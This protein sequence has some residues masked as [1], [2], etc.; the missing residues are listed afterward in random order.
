MKS[1][2]VWAFVAFF[3]GVSATFFLFTLFL[4]NGECTCVGK[5]E[6]T[7]ADLIGIQHLILIFVSVWATVVIMVAVRNYF[8]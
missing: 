4:L 2:T 1:T 8:Q 7:M 6:M 3:F 5:R